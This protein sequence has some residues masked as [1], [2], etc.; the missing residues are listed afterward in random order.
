MRIVGNSFHN[1]TRQPVPSGW[2][3]EGVSILLSENSN[4]FV[5]QRNKFTNSVKNIA[6]AI[7]IWARTSR[8][9]I[10]ENQFTD[11][12][13]PVLGAYL[14]ETE[15]SNNEFKIAALGARALEKVDDR[16]RFIAVAM[17]MDESS[18]GRFGHN[19]FTGYVCPI[20]FSG[21]P[22]VQTLLIEDNTIAWPAGHRFCKDVGVWYSP[23]A[24]GPLQ[25]DRARPGG[26]P[27]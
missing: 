18:F 23:E 22:K 24:F 17:N 15:L 5:I 12:E 16:A 21:T 25:F 2:T 3:S 19:T 20:Q 9:T 11:L 10:I 27:H 6:H 13:S 4:E 8:A 1:L 14:G 26:M 7:G